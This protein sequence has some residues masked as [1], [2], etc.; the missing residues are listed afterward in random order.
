MRDCGGVRQRDT[1]G[2]AAGTHVLVDGE[3]VVLLHGIS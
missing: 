3:D 2:L 1:K